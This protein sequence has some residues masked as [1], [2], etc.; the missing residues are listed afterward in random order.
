MQLQFESAAVLITD[1]SFESSFKQQ[2]QT[3]S[4]YSFR[5]VRICC[6]V[7]DILVFGGVCGHGHVKQGI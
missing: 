6:F 7:R 4:G 1:E 5:N 3:L 2:C